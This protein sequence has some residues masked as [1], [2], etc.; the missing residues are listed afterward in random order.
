MAKADLSADRLRELLQYNPDTGHFTNR[1]GRQVGFLVPPK[2][3]M[4]ILVDGRQWLAHRLAWL[5]VHGRWP[6]EQID[7]ING[8]KTDNRLVNLREVSP[9]VNMQNVRG[10]KKNNKYAGLLGAHW[11]SRHGRWV[12]QLSIKGKNRYLGRFDTPEQAHAAYIAAKRRLH[13]GCTI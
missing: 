2:N 12:S 10:P 13:E 6:H 9:E 3:Y 5:Y 4:R 1:S 8:V 11:D 7:H